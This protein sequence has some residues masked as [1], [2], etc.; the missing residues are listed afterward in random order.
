MKWMISSLAAVALA[1]TALAHSGATGVV[2]DRMEA[3]KAMA[4]ALEVIVPMTR[5]ERAYDPGAYAAAARRIAAEAG[6]PLVDKFP[7][8]STQS[9]SEAAPAIWTDF[10]RFSDLS[11]TLE[12]RAAALAQA[13]DN[14]AEVPRGAFRDMAQTCSACHEDYRIETD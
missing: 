2:K 12:R 1:G 9:P 13:A 14:S 10:A 7:E 3:M 5:G 11:M 4:D 8:G 6:R